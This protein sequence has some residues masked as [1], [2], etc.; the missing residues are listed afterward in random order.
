MPGCFC[1]PDASAKCSSAR[2]VIGAQQYLRCA[3][4]RPRPRSITAAQRDAGISSRDVARHC[5]AER[6]RRDRRRCRAGACRE[7]VTH[8]GFRIAPM[9]C[10]TRSPSSCDARGESRPCPP[11]PGHHDALPLLCTCGQRVRPPSLAASTGAPAPAHPHMALSDEHDGD[12]RRTQGADPALPLR[13]ALARGAPCASQ[14]GV[15]HFHRRAGAGRGPVVERER[16]RPRRPSK[17]DP[18]NG[19]RSPRT[20]DRFPTLTAARLFDMVKARGYPGGPDHFRHR[21]A[22]HCARTA[23]AKRICVFAPCPASRPRSTGR[24]SESSPSGVPSAPLMAFV[25]G[26]SYSP[27][28]LRAL[29]PQRLARQPSSAAMSRRVSVLGG[30]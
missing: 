11:K 22:P 26:L 29:F 18:Y 4:Q 3:L 2:A 9:R 30:G 8:H 6:Q 25:L 20:L 28:P 19:V 17:L 23:R 15:H 1:V 24:T 7:K 14:L 5:H 13:R 16:R 21:I 10:C 12:R 27:L